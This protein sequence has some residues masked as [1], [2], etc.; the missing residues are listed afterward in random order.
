MA[1]FKHKIR[2][3]IH[4]AQKAVTDAVS[5]KLSRCMRSVS[6]KLRLTE[7]MD[8]F[9]TWFAAH[10]KLG[11]SIFMVIMSGLVVYSVVAVVKPKNH[12]E[13]VKSDSNSGPMMLEKINSL[14]DGFRKTKLTESEII[15]QHQIMNEVASQIHREIDSISALPEM[16]HKDSVQLYHCYEAW[17]LLVNMSKVN[18]NEKN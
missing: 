11:I 13:T 7:R 2:N 6:S 12:V 14:F 10:K 18:N 16:T 17:D 8:S 9:I 4:T 5:P 1:K 3:S 15:Q